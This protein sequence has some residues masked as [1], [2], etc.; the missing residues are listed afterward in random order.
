MKAST[1]PRKAVAK[2][3]AK[4]GPISMRRALAD[5]ALLGGILGGD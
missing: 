4:G 1:E 3:K 5:K 2:A